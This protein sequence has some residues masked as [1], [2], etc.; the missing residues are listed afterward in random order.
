[1]AARDY[2]TCAVVFVGHGGREPHV[3]RTRRVALDAR[4]RRAMRPDGMLSY[5][6]PLLVDG[7][8]GTADLV[9]HGHKVTQN[10]L[11]TTLY[12]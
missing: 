1:M 12:S 4:E 3:A 11:F 6:F 5:L 2:G 7:V 10:A 9:P 8:M